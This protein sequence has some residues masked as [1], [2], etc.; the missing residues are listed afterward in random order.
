M[1]L[2]VLI[3]LLT[4]LACG[5][6]PLDQRVK[7]YVRRFESACGVDSYVK[8]HFKRDLPGSQ[9]GLCRR[10]TKEVFLSEPF[11][12]ISTDLQREMLVF[13]ELGHCVLNQFLHR[14]NSIMQAFMMSDAHYWKYRDAY[15]AELCNWEAS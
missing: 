2:L 10:W 13:H 1:K 8:I 12:E 3:L 4:V 9:I 5:K 6:P 11:W 7:E 15:I 14:D